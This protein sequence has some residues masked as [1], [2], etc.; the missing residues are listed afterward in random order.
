[1]GFLLSCQEQTSSPGMRDRANMDAPEEAYEEGS[2]F[3]P[4]S[5]TPDQSHSHTHQT[6]ALESGGKTL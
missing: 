6:P 1:M 3:L 2:D 5:T 4:V